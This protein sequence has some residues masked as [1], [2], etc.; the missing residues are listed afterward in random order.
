MDLARKRNGL[1]FTCIDLERKVDRRRF[2]YGNP[3]GKPLHPLL[4]RG[5][6]IG[7]L[8]LRENGR[9]Y[10]DSLEEARQHRFGAA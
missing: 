3:G 1:P 2:L 6:G 8:Q 10:D 4:N 7:L 9:W 5:W